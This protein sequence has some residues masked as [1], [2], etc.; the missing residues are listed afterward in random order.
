MGRLSDDWLTEYGDILIVE[1]TSCKPPINC[2]SPD[3]TSLSAA[4][5]F[6]SM[7]VGREPQAQLKAY[8]ACS[9]ALVQEANRFLGLTS[10]LPSRCA[11]W[12]SNFC[13]WPMSGGCF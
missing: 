13:R 8:T 5:N 10:F 7:S 9:D 1:T 6:A 3:G 11:L 4:C 2:T 12:R